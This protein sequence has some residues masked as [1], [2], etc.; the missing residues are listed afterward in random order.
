MQ[1][2]DSDR[3]N[4]T[5]SPATKLRSTLPSDKTVGFEC[6]LALVLLQKYGKEPCAKIV[7]GLQG[8]K[9]I[10]DDFIIA[11]FGDTTEE[12]YKSLEQNERSFFTRCR[13]WNLKLNKQKVKCAQTNVP[14]MGHLLTPEGVKPDPGKIEAIVAMPEQLERH[15]TEAVPRNGQLPFQIHVASERNDRTVATIRR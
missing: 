3:R 12:A 11:G 14:F 1:N 7:E 9:V 8:V 13:E 10:A 6:L 2:T 5:S 15:S 4:L